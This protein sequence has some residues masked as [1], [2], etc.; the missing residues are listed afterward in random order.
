MQVEALGATLSKGQIADYFRVSRP[1]FDKIC[2]RQPEVLVRYNAGKARAIE[3][4]ANGL[5][6]KALSGDNTAAIFYLKSQ[7]GWTEKQQI[8]HTAGGEPLTLAH[9]YGSKADK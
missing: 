2:A 5:L 6:Q 1:T 4:V 8:D 9:F 7:A 3:R